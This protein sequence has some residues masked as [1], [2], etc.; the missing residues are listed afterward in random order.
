MEYDSQP[1]PKA[2]G[3]DY[4]LGA[5]K[6]PFLK[7][8]NTISLEQP[9]GPSFKVEGHKVKWGNWEFHVKP[10]YRAGIVISQ[11]SVRDPETDELRSVLYKGF[12]SELFVPYMD[13]TEG[14]YFRTY[15][16]AGEYGLGLQCMSLQPLNDCPRNAYYMDATFIDADGKPYIRSNMICIFESYAG[17]IA[18]RHTESPIS[19]QEVLY[20]YPLPLFELWS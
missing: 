6:P 13:P 2:E 16:D 4:R 12:A 7:P 3:T 5:Q 20:N 1:L 17:D 14:W 9:D 11:A 19:D 10:D 18:W 8:L 15:M